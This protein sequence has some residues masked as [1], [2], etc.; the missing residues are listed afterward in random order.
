MANEISVTASLSVNKPSIMS[1]AIGRAVTGLVFNM[2][3]NFY[4][5]GTISVGTS[6]TVIPLGQV[7]TPHWTFFKN[8]DPTNF[9]TIRNGAGG[10]DLL[11]LLPGEIAI[12]PL[13]DGSVPYA[14]AN[15]AAALLEYLIVGL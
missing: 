15:T 3:A 2:T 8:V 9:I 12:C 14:V 5:E 11:K 13:L 6:A 7:S 4:S 10:A 1:I